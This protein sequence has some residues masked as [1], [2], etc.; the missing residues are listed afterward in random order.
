MA[1]ITSK[2]TGGSDLPM[3]ER[4]TII[5][6]TNLSKQFRGWL[7][8]NQVSLDISNRVTGLLGPNGSGKSTLIKH[9]LGLIAPT[10]GHGTVFGLDIRSDRLQ[11]RQRIGYMPEDDCYIDG[12]T[13]VEMV[14]MSAQFF[15]MQRLE[16]LRRAHEILDFCG[17]RQE[18]YREI[19]GYST[20]MRQQIKFAAAIVHNPDFLILD[21]PTSGLDPEERERLLWRV[22]FLN[23]EFGMGVLLST[24]ILP[25]VQLI[26]DEVVILAGGQ[27]RAHK[28]LEELQ[29]RRQWI[30]RFD[31]TSVQQMETL[32]R[33]AR[34]QGFECHW[35]KTA[36]AYS[37]TTDDVDLESVSD[38]IWRLAKEANIQVRQLFPTEESLEQIFLKTIEGTMHA[39]S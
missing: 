4:Q 38:S 28:L 25:D 11:I 18:R 20:G 26:C 16:A 19:S 7:A 29:T 14:Q 9:L 10:H 21:E 13:G 33:L 36:E 35:D 34:Q 17:F 1:R 27:V 23:R 2:T 8:L 37:L 22:Q 5:E 6:L 3:P 32:E 24:H 31:M 39:T 30:L 12:I 15:G